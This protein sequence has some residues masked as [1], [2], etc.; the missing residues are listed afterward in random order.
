MGVQ[1]KGGNNSAGLANVSATYELQVVTPQ[2]E[3]NAGFVQLST[4]ADPGDVLG[5]RT[6][7]PLEASDDFR[8]RVGLDQTLYN[9]SFE[10]TTIATHIINQSLSTMTTNQASGYFVLNSG[11][12]TANGNYAVVTTRRTFPLYGTYPTY[13]DLWIR[14]GNHN[15]T[16]AISE[17]GLGYAA[18]T[19]A[20]TDGVFFRRNTSGV[21][22]AVVNFGGTET[23]ATIDTTN[24]AVRSGVGAYDPSECNHFLIVIHNDIANFWVND[25]L[26]ASIGCPDAQPSLTSSASQPIFTRVYNTGISS[27]GRRV[28]IGFLNVSLG[29]QH[30]NKPWS[31]ALCGLG[32]GAYQNQLGSTPAQT[33]NWNNSTAPVSITS[34]SNTAAGGAGQGYSTLGGQFALA[35]NATNET[36]WIMFGYQNPTGT[37]ALPGKTLYIT[38]IRVCGLVVT[39]AAAVNATTFFWAAGVGS[40]AVSL[41]TTDASASVAPKRVPLGVQS[42]LAAAP[43]GTM[44]PGFDVQFT[45]APLVVPAGTYMHI[46]L[47]QLNGAATASL[48]WRGQVMVN[49]Y[50]E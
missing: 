5:T 32:Q 25:T 45:D 41:A 37:N 2:T 42:F 33:A 1:I 10:G 16:N 21:L 28:E 30:N 9:Q 7:I 17:W 39:G 43:L 27:T 20:P 44:A 3:I 29:D 13:T 38:S 4:E 22:K 23:E 12:A 6:V 50:F 18:T 36:D 26:V 11:N 31:H 34:P 14:E 24:V 40:S 46:I 47:K 48:V 49:G 35:A 8:L 15:A 19:T